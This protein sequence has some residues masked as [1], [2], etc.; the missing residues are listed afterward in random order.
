MGLDVSHNAFS[1][2]YSAFNRL[3][4]EVAYAAGGSFPPHWI[5]DS[6]G[7]VVL[8]NNGSPVKNRKL[9]DEYIYLPDDCGDGL[10]EF[11]AHSDCDG[12]ISPEMCKKVADDLEV[13]ADKMEEIEAVGH[14]RKYGTYA[15]AVRTF[16][17][18]CRDAHDA[19]ESLEFC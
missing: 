12:E 7:S 3:R 4:Q 14:L 1:G 19:N 15:E 5:R 13:V 18:G 8:D 17:A 11:L 9:T 6:E 2:A 10:R 16:A